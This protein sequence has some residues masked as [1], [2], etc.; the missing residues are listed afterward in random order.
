V[1]AEEPLAKTLPTQVGR[2][3]EPRALPQR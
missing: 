3:P 2:E 1:H